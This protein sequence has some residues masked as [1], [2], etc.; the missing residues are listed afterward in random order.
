MNIVG[1]RLGAS[2]IDRR[3]AVVERR[4]EDFHHLPVAV[5][6]AGELFP[7][8]LDRRWQQPILERGAV[9]QRAR[10][11][12]QHRNV[13]PGIVGRLAAAK[14]ARVL[15]DN[16][17]VLAEDDPVGV[18]LEFDRTADGA[19]ANRVFVVVVV[20]AHQAGFG[21][22]GLGGVESIEAA[23]RLDKLGPL[24]LENLEEVLS[25]ISGCL[26]ALA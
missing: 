11:F 12:R 4:R 25:A 18:S 14:A 23:W 21:H 10:L 17:A 16:H 26:C 20:E 22:G 3:Q 24:V 9:A 5:V 8:L 2:G 1:E 6:G 19:G 13:M 7:D 15:P